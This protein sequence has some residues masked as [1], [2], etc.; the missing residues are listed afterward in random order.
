MKDRCPFCNTKLKRDGENALGVVYACP[1]TKCTYYYHL[2]VGSKSKV[3]KM[4]KE[5]EKQRGK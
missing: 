3:L 1:N 4:L 2:V 5:N